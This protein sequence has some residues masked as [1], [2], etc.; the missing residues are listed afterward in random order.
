MAKGKKR[1]IQ[2][3]TKGFNVVVDEFETDTE[4]DSKER[5]KMEILKVA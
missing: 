3:N 4:S 5:K 2:R 1:R